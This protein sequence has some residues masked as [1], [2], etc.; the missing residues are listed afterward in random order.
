M[1]VA[2]QCRLKVHIN[3]LS[4][5]KETQQTSRD[6]LIELDFLSISLG[7]IR[8]EKNYIINTTILL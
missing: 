2:Q 4:S 8:E 3:N 7:E 6:N 5:D 1:T